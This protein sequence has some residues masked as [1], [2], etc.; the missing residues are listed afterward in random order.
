MRYEVK[1]EPSE[2]DFEVREFRCISTRRV[3]V[4]VLLGLAALFL[5]GA[6]IYGWWHGDF[7]GLREVADYVRDPMWVLVGYYFG[8]RNE[9]IDHARPNGDAKGGI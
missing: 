2:P 3:V 9:Q 1:R 4:A 8:V 6:A 7:N 5:T